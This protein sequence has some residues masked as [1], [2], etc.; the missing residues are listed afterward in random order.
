MDFSALAFVPF[1]YYPVS[2][3]IIL[4]CWAANSSA[5]AAVDA[6]VLHVALAEPSQL[7]DNL[8]IHLVFTSHHFPPKRSF[9]LL[10]FS[11]T[12]HPNSQLIIASSP[13][14]LRELRSH[15]FPRSSPFY[16]EAPPWNFIRSSLN[17]HLSPLRPWPSSLLALEFHLPQ[18]F[19]LKYGELSTTWA[20]PKF[21]P[22]LLSFCLSSCYPFRVKLFWRVVHTSCRQ[23]ALSFLLPPP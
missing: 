19:L 7:L 9:S 12:F 18:W 4:G 8:F 13:T 16:P 14:F 2:V 10:P 3:Q 6:P 17:L 20:N 21:S 23:Y 1:Q 15:V 22:T 5:L 11:R